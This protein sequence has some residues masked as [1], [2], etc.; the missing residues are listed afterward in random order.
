M[1]RQY[2]V[3]DRR[4]TVWTDMDNSDIPQFPSKMRG[5]NIFKHDSFTLGGGVYLS[6]TPH[7]IVH[8]QIRKF[9]NH[10]LSRVQIKFR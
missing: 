3:Y 7:P 9:Q 2:I 6:G 5:D 8:G 10:R 4:T 1:T